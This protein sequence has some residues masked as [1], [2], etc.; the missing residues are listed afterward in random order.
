[1]TTT[2]EGKTAAAERFVYQTDELIIK[3]M[4]MKVRG[5]VNHKDVYDLKMPEYNKW[6]KF[7]EEER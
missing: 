6:V 3:F 2:K 5:M 1:M 7:V 4:H